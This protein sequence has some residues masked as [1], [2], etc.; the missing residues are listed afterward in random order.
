MPFTS[1]AI[2][3]RIKEHP[4]TRWIESHEDELFAGNHRVVTL[5]CNR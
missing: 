5:V 1:T 4:D 3:Q 2:Y